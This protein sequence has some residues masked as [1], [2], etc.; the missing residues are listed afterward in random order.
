MRFT[1]CGW[2]ARDSGMRFWRRCGGGVCSGGEELER[3]SRREKRRH[4]EVLRNRP[5]VDGCSVDNIT[6]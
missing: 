6:K 4:I 3:L 1:F 2:G 5:G